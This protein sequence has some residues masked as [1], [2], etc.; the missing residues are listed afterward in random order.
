MNSEPPRLL[1]REPAEQRQSR[2]WGLVFVAGVTTALFLAVAGFGFASRA[3]MLGV[4]AASGLWLLLFTANTFALRSPHLHLALLL[5]ALGFMGPMAVLLAWYSAVGFGLATPLVH[6]AFAALLVFMVALSWTEAK[7]ADLD[8]F[9]KELRS[10]GG[11]RPLA[12]GTTEFRMRGTPKTGP[13]G[14]FFRPFRWAK[15]LDIGFACTFAVVLMV[16]APIVFTQAG[17]TDRASEAWIFCVV[18][19]GAGWLLRASLTGVLVNLRL[20]R[21]LRQ[22]PPL[23]Q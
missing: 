18:I 22:T 12:D 21:A 17:D 11:L 20:L 4:A 23:G 2:F 6:L 14:P 3:H 19:L 7:M 5:P 8:A 15:W 10:N 9:Q 16:V 13:Y 1:Y